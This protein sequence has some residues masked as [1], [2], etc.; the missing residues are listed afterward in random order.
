MC[1]RA[2][3]VQPGFLEEAAPQ[4]LTGA[5]VR[6]SLPISP[7]WHIVGAEEMVP[8]RGLD[9][10]SA[11]L[12]GRQQ[13]TPLV[14]PDNWDQIILSEENFLNICCTPGRQSWVSEALPPR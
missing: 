11:R 14:G 5:L 6:H 10:S 12:A 1:N 8:W 3:P 7:A 4:S 9:R 13:Q 2:G